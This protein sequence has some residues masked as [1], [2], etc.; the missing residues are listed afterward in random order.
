LKLGPSA[1]GDAGLR[2]IEMSPSLLAS[3]MILL[4]VP[5]CA[6]SR[7]RG[8][9]GPGFRGGSFPAFHRIR[10]VR[11]FFFPGYVCS[12]NCGLG[13]VSEGYDYGDGGGYGNNYGYGESYAR[14]AE[15]AASISNGLTAAMSPIP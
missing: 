4:A 2:R 1:A 11:G 6:G 14:G 10:R 15:G 7:F 5:A 8:F 3:L 13:F 12:Y 9:H